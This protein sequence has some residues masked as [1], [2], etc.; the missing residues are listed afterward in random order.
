VKPSSNAEVKNGGAIPPL[1]D[2]SAWHINLLI[3][4]SD[5]FIF[6]VLS[7]TV[8]SLEHHHFIKQ[9]WTISALCTGSKIVTLMGLTSVF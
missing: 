9:P 7:V 6:L 2:M 3:R 5:N 8:F 4:Y 1:S